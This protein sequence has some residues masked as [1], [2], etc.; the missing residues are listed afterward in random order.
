MDRPLGPGPRLP[1]L[2]DG[3]DRP[4]PCGAGDQRG[5]AADQRPTPLD[6]RHLRLHGRGLPRDDGHARGPD[7]SAQAVAHR[8]DGVRSRL[9]A[10]RLLDERG[11]AHR[12]PR[13]AGHRRRHA[14][15]LD[16]VPDL[17]DVP[18]PRSA[19]AR[20]RRLDLGLFRGECDRPGPRRYPARAVLVGLRVPARAA[21]DG[22]PP[23]HRTPRPAGVQ[24]TGRRATRPRRAQACR[25][26]RS[27]RS[28]SGSSRWPRTA[29]A[30]RPSSR[31]RSAW[32]WARCSSGGNSGWPTR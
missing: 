18:G 25:S 8:R 24:G 16:A 21:G 12:Q 17:R 22:R 31:S 10:R 9:G 26:S 2:R 6:H 13:P 4:A 14:R 15:P 3:P 11:D 32:S 7:R 1:P 30:R 19:H 27:C 5:P 29:S 28:S 23:D 20:G